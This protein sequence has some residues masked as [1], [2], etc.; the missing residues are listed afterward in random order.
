MQINDKYV[1]HRC[2]VFIQYCR[3]CFRGHNLDSKV[4]LWRYALLLQEGVIL[5]G[6]ISLK[7]KVIVINDKLSLITYSSGVFP[8][9]G[10]YVE[11]YSLEIKCKIH[12]SNL[13]GS[14]GTYYSIL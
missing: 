7:L 11:L 1:Q 6:T 2:L 12:Y 3:A 14:I 9:N 13:L 10:L 4:K 8:T 5:N